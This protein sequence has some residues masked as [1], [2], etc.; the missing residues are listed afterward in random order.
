MHIWV[1]KSASVQK[2]TS[3]LKLAAPPA[4]GCTFTSYLA[5]SISSD[6]A[7]RVRSAVWTS[8]PT[9]SLAHRRGT[10][11]SGLRCAVRG[12]RWESRGAPLPGLPAGAGTRVE[13]F[14][15]RAIE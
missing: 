10:C 2:R 7:L 8:H 13:R 12:L 6:D 5:P 15:W 14:D 11:E 4:S 1:E 3:S 9:A